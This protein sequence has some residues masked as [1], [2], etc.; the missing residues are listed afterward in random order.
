MM[1]TAKSGFQSVATLAAAIAAVTAAGY[2]LLATNASHSYVYAEGSRP[3]GVARFITTD[4]NSTAA[5]SGAARFLTTD[6]SSPNSRAAVSQRVTGDYAKLQGRWIGQEIGARGYWTL[7]VTGSTLRL[8]HRATTGGAAEVAL[9]AP[10]A[11][12]TLSW[13]RA[14]STSARELS[15]IYRFQGASLVLALNDGGMP[16]PASFQPGASR[17]LLVLHP[18]QD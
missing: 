8:E 17:H 6:I 15:A 12:D 18:V 16:A 5:I 11:L 14:L 2:L 7:S 3:Q 13:P 9:S 10:Y 4:I 1:S